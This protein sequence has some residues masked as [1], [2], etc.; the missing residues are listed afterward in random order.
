MTVH[1]NNIANA[2]REHLARYSWDK[3]LNQ[4]PGDT[5]IGLYEDQ[6]KG[7]ENYDNDSGGGEQREV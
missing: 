4:M 5:S 3:S 1:D 2:L 7:A 6:S